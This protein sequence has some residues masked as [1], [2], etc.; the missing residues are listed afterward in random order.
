MTVPRLLIVGGGGL[1][2]VIAHEATGWE[3]TVADSNP[4]RGEVLDV[5]NGA[6]VALFFADHGPFDS[7]VYTA[8]VNSPKALASIA[9]TRSLENEMDVNFFGAMRCLRWFV[10]QTIA[11]DS[12]APNHFVAIS[13][14][15]AQVARSGSLGYCASKAALSMGVRCA[16]RAEAA[17]PRTIWAVEPG[18]LESTPMSAEVMQRLD[19]AP[20]HRIPGD[21]T[22]QTLSLARFI[23]DTVSR[24]IRWFNGC[25]I[26]LD[27]GEQ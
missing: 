5:T 23:M 2:S 1:G 3:V 11:P 22:V 4:T 7:V 14:N 16:A 25:T 21:R 13:S 18:W 24:D 6:R 17:T 20:A 26:R 19:G 15:S 8:G 12:H 27:G 10:K 9:F